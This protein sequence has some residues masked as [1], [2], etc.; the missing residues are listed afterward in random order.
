[1][2]GKPEVYGTLDKM[3]IDYRV[4]E[5][6]PVYT[7][8]EMEGIGFPEGTEVVK[9]LFLRDAKGKRHFLVI[10]AGD[11]TANLKE[12]GG[13]VGAGNLSFASPERL[14]KYLKL[15]KGAVSPLGI[16]ND[17]TAAVEVILDRG[18]ENHNMVGVHPNVNTA[19]VLLR[20]Q[21]IVGIIQKNGNSITY[22]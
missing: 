11:K 7:I 17:E 14:Q 5:H 8:E 4:I 13:A 9:N 16:L 12:L 10:L 6:Q 1:M 18:L 19:T 2:R 22:I 15:E 21:D 3:G 20:F